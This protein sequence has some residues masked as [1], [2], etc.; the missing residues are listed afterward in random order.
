MGPTAI[1]LTPPRTPLSPITDH[2]MVSFPGRAFLLSFLR[3]NHINH[4]DEAEAE[5]CVG[6]KNSPGIIIPYPGLF[7]PKLKVNGRQ[8]CRLRLDHP[9]SS[10]K[11]LSPKIPDPNSTSRRAPFRFK[12]LIISKANSKL[13][14]FVKQASEPWPLAESPPRCRKANC[15]PISKT[16][17]QIQPAYR[18]FFGRRRHLPDLRLQPGGG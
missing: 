7:T 6:Y 8:F 11:Y 15:S 17:P 13:S 18:L 12:V 10:A 2:T 14:P 1:I 9:T 16:S 3:R 4:V 5:Q